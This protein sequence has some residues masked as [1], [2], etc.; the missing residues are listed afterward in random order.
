MQKLLIFFFLLTTVQLNAQEETQKFEIDPETGKIKFQAVV[1]EE[2]TQEQ[3]FNRCI[4]FI[5]DFYKD[6]VRVTTIRD[7]TSGK[8]EGNYRFRIYTTEKG[9]QVDAGLINYNFIIEMKDGKYRY[10]VTDMYLKSATNKPIERWLDKDDPGYDERQEDYL[11][12]ILDY[13]ENWSNKLKE[14]MK[15]E[16][17]KKK[18][19]W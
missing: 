12:Q 8:I 18:D 17:E 1:E 6:P 16:P 4:Y 19:E 7:L 14:K 5:N 9:T 11:Q 3:L 13:F 15:P 10:S 2:G